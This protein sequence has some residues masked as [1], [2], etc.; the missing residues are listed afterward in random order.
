MSENKDGSEETKEKVLMVKE[1]VETGLYEDFQANV[2]AYGFYNKRIED[3]TTSVS[4]HDVMVQLDFPDGTKELH[5][6]TVRFEFKHKG[7]IAK[8]FSNK[9]EPKIEYSVDVQ[10]L[11]DQEE[12]RYSLNLKEL[13]VY[14]EKRANN[15]SRTI[16]SVVMTDGKDYVLIHT[17]NAQKRYD[18]RDELLWL[19]ILAY[20]RNYFTD[21]EYITYVESRNQ[22]SNSGNSFFSLFGTSR[23][24]KTSLNNHKQ[25]ENGYEELEKL[26]GLESIKKDIKEL[27]N[28]LKMQKKRKEKGLKTVPMS[29]H[30]VF[31]GNPGTGKTTIARILASIYK[32]IGALSKGH[33]VEVD[34]ADLVAEYIGQTAPKTAAKIKEAMG[35]ILFIDEAY[36]LAKSDGKDFGQEAID[37]LLKAMEDHREDFI[38]I[39]AGYPAEMHRFI[40][41]NPG[42]K[43]RFNKYINFPD[44]SA[45]ELLQIFKEMCES[46]EYHLTKEAEELVEQEIIFIEKHKK[47]NFANARTIR[48]LFEKVITKQA[49]RLAE[50]DEDADLSELTAEDIREENTTDPEDNPPRKEK[51]NLHVVE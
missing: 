33:V 7:E 23:G 16:Y 36:T 50:A 48:N 2:S 42:L 37:T 28:F 20:E 29:L 5:A 45:K 22:M 8:S 18:K 46:Y 30:L 35:G 38:V 40:N 39:V 24:G 10:I 1:K 44:Y 13:K 26:I 32:D 49:T 31:T 6:D 9:I 43:S 51:G 25:I 12:Y 21:K 4:S 15:Y 17:F 14:M 47:G 3:T 41:S 27:S 11:V 19:V 34:R